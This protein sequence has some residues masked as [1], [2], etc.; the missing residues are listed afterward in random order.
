MY[1]LA[2]GIEAAA[3]RPVPGPLPAAHDARAVIATAMPARAAIPTRTAIPA[4]SA[5]PAGATIPA[6]SAMMPAGTA[7]PTRSTAPAVRRRGVGRRGDQDLRE[8]AL[9]RERHGD[10]RPR[11]ARLILG[12]AP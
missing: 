7:I 2:I 9:R 10:P 8:Q 5:M 6:R 1:A 4:A 11:L 3:H 12:F